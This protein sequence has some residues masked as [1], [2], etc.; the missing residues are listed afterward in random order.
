MNTTAT[1][2]PREARLVA[3]IAAAPGAT[4]AELSKAIGVSERY[5]R[6][7]LARE[8]VRAALDAAA[9]TGIREAA[10]LLGRSATRAAR[11][12]VAMA[13]GSARA[14]APQVSA[15]RAVLDAL[16]PLTEFA[17]MDARITA[18]ENAWRDAQKSN[19]RSFS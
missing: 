16:V 5:V 14:T 15:C 10:A 8:S 13:D 18:L 11:S 2:S 3:A 17:T 9:Q 7:L 6:M 4:Q 12:L 1:L 19:D